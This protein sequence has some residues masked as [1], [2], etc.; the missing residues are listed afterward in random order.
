MSGTW[1]ILGATSGMARAFAR[2]A[3]EEKC[4]LLL[5]GRDQNELN[6]LA[7]DLHLRGSPDV[8]VINF[9]ARDKHSRTALVEKTKD[10]PGPISVFLAFGTMPPEEALRHEPDLCAEMMAANYIGAALVLNA[11]TPLFEARKSGSVIVLGSVAGDR[12]RKKNYLYGSSKAGLHAYVQ[13]LA[14]H[15]SDFNVPVLL[16][17]PGVIDTGMTWGLKN[18]PL[19]LGTPEG[20]ATACWAKAQKGGV[21]YFPWF[22]RFVMLAIIHLPRKIFNKLNF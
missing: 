4:A 9:D 7:A 2:K 12:G 16:V 19:P 13:G 14:A 21:L 1:I 10:L 11:L 6:I 18:P 17:K 8:S 20:L 15:L 3:A 5:A 22:W